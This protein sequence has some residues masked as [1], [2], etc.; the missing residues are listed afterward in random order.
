MSA[1]HLREQRLVL[2]HVRAYV[3]RRSTCSRPICGCFKAR[4]HSLELRRSSVSFA[5][6]SYRWC[7][8]HS[9]MKLNSALMLLS[10]RL[11]TTVV[12]LT[13]P[14]ATCCAV[15]TVTTASPST[16]DDYDKSKPFSSIPGPTG[17]PYFGTLFYYR[18]GINCFGL[19][20]G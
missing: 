1:T 19:F 10:R 7:R 6:L 17:L 14:G 12:Q 18:A 2:V 4:R 8:R 16:S 5:S 13:K 3:M 11:R 15:R 20:I 9:A